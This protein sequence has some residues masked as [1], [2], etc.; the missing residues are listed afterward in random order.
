MLHLKSKDSSRL[1]LGF[2]STK[3]GYSKLQGPQVYPLALA[4]FSGDLG[5]V[6]FFTECYVENPETKSGGRFFSS[7]AFRATI[8]QEAAFLA[9]SDPIQSS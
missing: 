7:P 6:F 4:W 5:K 3:P 2:P 8:G 9:L 1:A